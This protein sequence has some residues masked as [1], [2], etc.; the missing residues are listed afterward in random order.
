[1]STNINSIPV[2]FNENHKSLMSLAALFRENFSI[3]WLVELTGNKASEILAIFEEGCSQGWLAINKPG[4]FFFKDSEKKRIW[5][6][7]LTLDQEKLLHS[8]IANFLLK[9]LPSNDDNILTLL[10]H[11]LEITND[12]KGCRWLL[13]A[14]DIHLR[15]FHNEEA[16]LCYTKVLNDISNLTGEAADS[17]FI[18]AAIK[19]FKICRARHDT[20]RVISVLH[21]AMARARRWN[22]KA[23]LALLK[24]HMA[25]NE[26]LQSQYSNAMRHF[27]QGWLM[28]KKLND[29]KLLDSSSTFRT[30]FLFWQGCFKEVVRNYENSGLDVMKFLDDTFPFL[31]VVSV[32]RSYAHIGQVTKAMEM[33]NTIRIRCQEK[34][35]LYVATNA[36]VAMA[37]ILL[38]T[39]RVD[40]AFQLL[41]SI[42]KETN[43]EHNDWILF[44]VRLM[45]AF[46]YYLEG[47]N[48]Q[49]IVYLHKFLEHS[50][51][52]NVT[53]RLSHYLMEL[54]WAMEQGKLAHI[55]N[56]SLEK[57]VFEAIRSE[58]IFLRGVAYRFQSFL[59][60]RNGLPHEK[61][62]QSLNLSLRWLEESGSQ[63]EQARTQFDLAREY[64]FL[65]DEKK[66]KETTII[67]SNILS[68]F[69]KSLLPDDLKPFIMDQQLN[70]NLLKEILKVGQEICSIREN[71]DLFQH[72]ISSVNRII[73]A[74]RGAIFLLPRNT[75]S[76]RLQLRASKNI[77]TIQANHPS[78][79]SSMKMIEEVVNTGRGYVSDMNSA[80]D[81]GFLPAEIIRSRICVPIVSRNKVLGALYCDNRLLSSVFKESDLELLSYFTTLTAFALDNTYTYKEIQELNQKLEQEK[82]H[83]EEQP[84]QSH[85]FIEIVGVSPAIM[86]VLVQVDQL[87]NTDTAVLISGETGVGKELAAKAIHHYSPRSDKP[88]IRVNCAV[89]PDSLIGSELFGHEKGAFTD[90]ISRRIG[91]FELANGGTLF[92]DEIDTLSPLVQVSLLRVLEFKEF[93]RI[94]GSETLHSDFRLIAATNR[95]LVQEVKA[96]RLRQDLYYRLNVFPIYIPPLR[97][98][99]EDIPLLAHYFLKIYAA[100]TEKIFEGIPE[101]EM[102]KLIKYDWPGNIRELENIIERGIILSTKPYFR[103]PELEVGLSGQ[104]HIRTNIT[105]EENERRH[106][107][108]ALQQTQWKIRGP[109]GAAELLDIHP[110]TLAFRMKKLGIHRPEGFLKK[111]GTPAPIPNTS[112]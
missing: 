68:Y 92:L 32:G 47:K 66:A 83:Q 31:A 72:I 53:L 9:E 16:L 11:L 60:K 40:D 21:E 81:N 71:N 104:T 67:A 4:I 75:H 29:P 70:E 7:Y 27:E 61:I 59:Q 51:Q 65:G 46:A 95:D 37:A 90:A 45:L 93:E 5:Q 101:E 62:I 8:R 10:P 22:K 24:M 82:L 86:R 44:R 13:G 98:R 2:T 39:S 49:T 80:E 14:G 76:F 96:G 42:L 56:L 50:R 64:L 79:S 78:F 105:L 84:H 38:D 87:V 26:L 97:E 100:R 102:N 3:D 106:I 1:M 35:N 36:G 108:W 85:H 30:L 25:E 58:N 52:V 73:G 28:A 43:Q 54:F 91:R 112:A 48:R 33:L 34:G 15:A 12:E 19:Y 110:S 74:E 63:I 111:R 18:E 57:E 109:S 89:F 94:G 107:L 55:P 99:R 20:H 77:T 41:R 103:V 23:S 69:N 88:F 17:I 6:N